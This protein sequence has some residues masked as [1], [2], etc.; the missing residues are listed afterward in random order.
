MNR[1]WLNIFQFAIGLLLLFYSVYRAD[2]LSF[3]YDESSTVM[4]FV[5]RNYSDILTQAPTANN[6]ILNTILI[7]FC[8]SFLP[9]SELTYRLPN[10]VA[11]LLYIGFSILLVSQ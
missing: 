6:H 3:T 8:S 2:H 10:L 5:G 9:P 7:K 11:H 1:F 4:E